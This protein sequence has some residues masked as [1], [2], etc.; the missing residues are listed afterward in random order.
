MNPLWGRKSE[1]VC[2]QY[3][4]ECNLINREFQWTVRSMMRRFE[5]KSVQD[6]DALCRSSKKFNPTNSALLPLSL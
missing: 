4:K 1:E 3:G 6:D 2:E 5:M